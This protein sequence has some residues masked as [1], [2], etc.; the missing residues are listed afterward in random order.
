MKAWRQWLQLRTCLVSRVQRAY[1]YSE[2][3]KLQLWLKDKTLHWALY[4]VVTSVLL[5][6]LLGFHNYVGSYL[7]VVFVGDREVGYVHDAFEIE[8][9]VAGL[10]QQ[11]SMLY[12][13]A[14]EPGEAVSLQWEHR[15]GQE[16]DTGAAK[17]ALRR[18]VTLV[19]D[20]VMIMVEQ[21]PVLPVASE[22]DVEMVVQLLSSAYVNEADNVVLLEVSLVEDLKG[23]NCIVAPEDVFSAD[24]VAALLMAGSAPSGRLLLS[25]GDQVAAV[26]ETN[27]GSIVNDMLLPTVN[28]ITLEEVTVNERIPFNTEYTFTNTLWTVQSNILT[29]G[30]DGSK[31]VVYHVT[32]E[33]GIETVRVKVS[34]KMVETPVT[35]IVQKGT[36][37]APA[38]GTGQFVWPV[39]GGG[40][41]TQGFRGWSHSGIDISYSSWANRYNTQILAA[42]SGVVVETGSQYPMGNHIVIFHGKYFTVYMHNQ[43]NFVSTGST[44]TRGQAIGLMGNT[45]RTYGMDG[46]HLHFEVRVNDGSGVWGHYR[47][48]QP[49]DPLGFF[50]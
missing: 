19:T 1:R 12:G 25:R 26:E 32:R 5:G 35:Q 45:G 18:Q 22:D 37:A 38:I 11:C 17:E 10:T 36:A 42:D 6:G 27:D 28:V 9:F 43:V 4:L 50:R 41:L 3:R 34:E 15:P 2:F 33:N 48:H 29:A 31:E 21:V 30:K 7:F 39:E 16:V 20:A 8:E 40:R 46:I 24:E 13:M 14:V 23:E 47:K 44:V 49:I